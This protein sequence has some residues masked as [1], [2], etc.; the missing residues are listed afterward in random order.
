MEEDKENHFPMPPPPPPTPATTTTTTAATHSLDTT[1]S[2]IPATA[3]GEAAETLSATDSLLSGWLSNLDDALQGLYA[4]KEEVRRALAEVVLRV[5][6][7]SCAQHGSEVFSRP[8]LEIKTG[9]LSTSFGAGMLAAVAVAAAGLANNRT[10]GDNG[11]S[12]YP[13]ADV[14]VAEPMDE[15]ADLLLAIKMSQEASG[16]MAVDEPVPTEAAL[17]GDGEVEEITGPTDS[18]NTM[19]VVEEATTSAKEEVVA[20]PIPAIPPPPSS[21][22]P[23]V[24][25]TP[26]EL[27]AAQFLLALTDDIRMQ[28]IAEHW[29][30][31]QSVL[32]LLLEIARLG[33]AQRTFLLKREIVA[34]L[35][36][37]IL[38][39]QCPLNGM[40]YATGS[41][42][43]AP[44]SYVTIVSGRDDTLPFVAKNIPDWSHLMELL[45]ALVCHSDSL[46]LGQSLGEISLQC[47]QTKTLY[48]TIFRQARYT[49]IA[50]PML[51]HLCYENQVFSNLILESLCDEL[52]QCKEGDTAHI[53]QAIDR[54]LNMSDTLAHS[55]NFQLF[56]GG[57]FNLLEIM[58]ITK[59]QIYK[60]RFICVFIRSF[61][62]LAEKSH[63]LRSVISIPA[64]KI[65]MWAPWMLKF[66]FRFIA[67]CNQEQQTLCGDFNTLSPERNQ[68]N[69]AIRAMG[70]PTAEPRSVSFNPTPTVCIPTTNSSSAVTPCMAA[71][72]A[73]SPPL[74]SPTPAGAG[75]F[76]RVYGEDALSESTQTWLQRAE[77]TFQGLQSLIVSLGGS[78]DELIPV[79][80]FDEDI[81]IGSSNTTGMSTQ[82][83]SAPTGAIY[84]Q[85]PSEESSTGRKAPV[86]LMQLADGMTDE[87]LAQILE[88]GG[89]GV[90]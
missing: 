36:D 8:E 45:T 39:D 76:L 35:V 17:A 64:S 5:F 16:M 21:T 20:P 2:T 42:R 61:I 60:H 29:R 49:T 27:L 22:P 54:L 65:S 75:P 78:P 38:G 74:P 1:A 32:W 7:A 11:N 88:G 70:G 30:K 52:G 19:E 57:D 23:A 84:P 58:K 73:V 48:N 9:L 40:V 47:L 69:Q 12:M 33:S 13:T 79:D 53:F 18:N 28:L 4:P 43:R 71:V 46:Q 59:D 62:A 86:N 25:P 66:C 87:E 77:R 80:T 44:S 10:I 51:V 14:A 24:P 15:D 3:P 83:S 41:R 90:D 81:T 37:A 55:R 72:G 85:L 34:Q 31:S 6:E 82:T 56:G 63:T 50:L 67:K 68:V 26:P 89:L